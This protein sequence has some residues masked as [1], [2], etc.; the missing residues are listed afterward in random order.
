MEEITTFE[1]GITE[2]ERI[3]ASLEGGELPLEQAVELFQKGKDVLAQC[4]R[5]LDEA[6]AKITTADEK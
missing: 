5:M 6:E 4:T 1:E 3:V 2:L